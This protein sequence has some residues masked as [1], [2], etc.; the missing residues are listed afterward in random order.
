[1]KCLRILEF[2]ARLWDIEV[3]SDM[4]EEAGCEAEKLHWRLFGDVL[5]GEKKET[6]E[7]TKRHRHKKSQEAQKA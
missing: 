1:L 6:G 5:Y 4:T 3:T 2:S 7:K